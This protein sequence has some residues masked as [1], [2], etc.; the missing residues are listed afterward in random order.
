MNKFEYE[1]SHLFTLKHY[2]VSL[3]TF[4][5]Y[6]KKFL[7]CRLSDM[8]NAKITWSSRKTPIYFIFR[9]YKMEID[10]IVVLTWIV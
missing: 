7:P 3:S 9:L 4:L 5:K 2:C 1:L 10:R 8:V 6:N